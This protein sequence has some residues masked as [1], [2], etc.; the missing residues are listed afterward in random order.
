MF[1]QEKNLNVQNEMVSTVQAQRYFE[2]HQIIGTNFMLVE[3]NASVILFWLAPDNFPRQRG[4][5]PKPTDSEVY[6][7]WWLFS[8]YLRNHL[9]YLWGSWQHYKPAGCIFQLAANMHRVSQQNS[10]QVFFGIA[11]VQRHICTEC[12]WWPNKRVILF[13]LE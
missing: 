6:F 8:L 11:A 10:L 5:S 9:S 7:T 2:K 13:L 12:I 3:N 4:N 1:K